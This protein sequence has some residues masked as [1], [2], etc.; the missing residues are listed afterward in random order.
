[1]NISTLEA[2]VEQENR[3]GAVFG[4][5]WRVEPCRD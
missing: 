1:M 2:L 3:W 4:L 5:R